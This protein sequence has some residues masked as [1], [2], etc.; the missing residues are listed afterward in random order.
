ML[1]LILLALPLLEL[2]LLVLL[3]KRF[4]WWVGLYL[5]VS[6]G[7]GIVMI[8]GEFQSLFSRLARQRTEAD[9][10]PL[11]AL[12]TGARNL[13][14]GLLFIFPGVL[15]DVMALLLLLAPVPQTP[16]PAQDAGVI[17]GEWRRED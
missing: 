11:R 12:L 6:A 7:I 4:G 14:V 9:M 1:R 13:I 3:A 10:P 5:L 16:Q 2:I 8:R 17:E 15:T